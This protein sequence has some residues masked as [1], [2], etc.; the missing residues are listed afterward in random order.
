MVPYARAV[1][2]V[3]P[4]GV[5]KILAV[6]SALMLTLMSGPAAADDEDVT[7]LC[8]PEVADNPCEIPLDTTVLQPDGGSHVV[9]PE[10]EP[11]ED[12]PFDCFYVYPTVSNQLTPNANKVASGEITSIARFQAAPYTSQCR[13]YAP[14]Y[15][16]ITLSGLATSVLVRGAEKAYDD[17]LAAWQA[18]LEND[19]DG[20]GV[21]FIG[22]S[23]GTLMLR[24]LLHEEIDPNPELRER[25]VGAL[26]LGGNVRTKLGSTVG[27][28]FANIPTC[29]SRGQAGCVVAYSTYAQD[30][31]VPFFGSA[32]FDLVSVLGGF[33]GGRGLQVACT[34]PRTLSGIDGPVGVTIP[35]K[36]FAPGP[37]W[38]GIEVSVLFQVPTASTTWVTSKDRYDGG[39]RSIRGANVYRYNPVGASRRPLE[40]PPTWGTHLFD[41]NLGLERL[42]SIVEQQGE[43][44]LARD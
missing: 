30:P 22:H 42:V 36:K 23:Q 32:N 18:Y 19:N 11:S 10:R 3:A 14:V 33:P 1:P 9:T 34:D 13:M 38:A 40:F 29:T 8:H 44:W 6:A 15:R 2:R 16:Q 27:G 24:K 37:I 39:C 26:L 25:M 12:R 28:D 31:V 35:T 17:V 5:G 41:G 4:I 43:T 7:W 21:V 20:R